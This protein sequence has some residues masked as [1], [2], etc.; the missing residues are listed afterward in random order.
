MFVELAPPHL[1]ARICQESESGADV[2]ALI[3][4]D[5]AG[6]LDFLPPWDLG[7]ELIAATASTPCGRPGRRGRGTWD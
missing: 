7:S 3:G 1:P 5:A 6:W 4:V 2:L